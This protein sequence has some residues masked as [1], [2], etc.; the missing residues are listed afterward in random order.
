MA[1][2]TTPR[3][4]FLHELGDILYVERKLAD[5]TL[6]TLIGEVQDDEL[7]SGLEKHLK[8]TRQHVT[9]VEKV[10]ESLGEP[11]EPEECIGFEGLKAEHDKLLEE[12]SPEL[13]DIVDLGAAARTE[14]YEI[15]AYESLRRL[16]KGLGEDDAV[17]LLDANLK[18]EKEA[19]REVEKIAT[20]I[21]NATAAPAG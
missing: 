16:A 12:T 2:I 14:N 11:A 6:P 1:E 5:E 10:F 4:L 21:S 7:R 18:E 19:L 8:E 15:A 17:E 3:D 20:R 9:N 13:I